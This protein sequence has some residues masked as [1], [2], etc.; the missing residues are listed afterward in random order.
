MVRRL[1]VDV[2]EGQRMLAFSAFHIAV[3]VALG[4]GALA[5]GA[6]AD[7]L[8]R[9]DNVFGTPEEDALRR[10]FT[11]NA[12]AIHLNPD[13]FGTLVDFFGDPI[14][15]ITAPFAGV[16]NYV[17]ATPPVS[18]DEPLAMVSRVRAQE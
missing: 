14:L 13:R 9:D 7:L 4:I 8:I 3:R 10:D 11:I 15:P 1:R 12:M 5:A 2:A 16:V 6:V 18:E 17:V